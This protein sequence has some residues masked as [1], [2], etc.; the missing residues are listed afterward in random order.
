MRRQQFAMG[1][2]DDLE[3]AKDQRQADRDQRIDEP[4]HQPVQHQLQQIG[5]ADFHRVQEAVRRSY[6]RNSVPVNLRE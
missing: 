4:E 2:I 1:E 3:H 6:I 5:G